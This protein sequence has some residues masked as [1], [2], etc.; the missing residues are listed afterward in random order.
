MPPIPDGLKTPQFLEAWN[1]LLDHRKEK[2]SPMTPTGATL[3]LKRFEEWGI[4]ETINNIEHSIRNGWTGVF[5]RDRKTN[6]QPTTQLTTEEW[7]ESW[8]KI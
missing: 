6:S 1:S 3:A 8:K 5:P 4:I 7:A 2:G